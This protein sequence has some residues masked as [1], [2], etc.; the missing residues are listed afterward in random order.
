MTVIVTMAMAAMDCSSVGMGLDNV[1]D[2][3]KGH[4]GGD[5]G[6]NGHVAKL[7][8]GPFP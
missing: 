8:D 1:A 6:E 7:K 2:D 5:P 3:L 4:E